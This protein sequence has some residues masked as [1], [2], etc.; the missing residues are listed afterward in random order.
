MDQSIPVF[1]NET[2]NNDI[3]QLELGN[4]L[5]ELFQR[6][7]H[8]ANRYMNNHYYSLLTVYKFILQE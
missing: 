3:G 4:E 2:V 7:Q 5:T 6:I 1:I 8:T